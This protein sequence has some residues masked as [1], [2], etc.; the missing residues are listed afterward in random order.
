MDEKVMVAM[1][2]AGA[3]LVTSIISY[4]VQ[5]AKLRHEFEHDI[6]QVRTS[7]MAETAA[8]EL[9]QQY[10]APFRTFIMIRHHV[11]G[12]SDDEL[13]RILVRAGALRFMSKSGRELWALYERV[14]NYRAS[15]DD[16]PQNYLSVW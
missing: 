3:A 14:K 5:R 7:F 12:F 6:A 10:E 1:V 4:L 15:W 11:G 2:G 13:R 16:K 9:L 8:R